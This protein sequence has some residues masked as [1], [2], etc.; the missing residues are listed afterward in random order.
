MKANN[1]KI[2]IWLEI[3][4]LGALFIKFAN[5]L[6]KKKAKIIESNFIDFAK[7]EEREVEKLIKGKENFNKFCCDSGSLIKDYFIPHNGNG[8]KPKILRTKSLLII[9][10]ITLLVKITVTGYLFFIYPNQA[11]MSEEITAKLLDLI[12][13]DRQNNNLYSLTVNPVL[14]KAALA[15]AQDMLANNY[16]AHYGPDGKKPWDW[17][18]RDAYPYLYAGENLAINFSSAGNVHAALMQSP[19][20]RKNILN[21]NYQNVGLAVLNGEINNQP[22]SILVEMFAGAKKVAPALTQ[23]QGVQ[24]KINQTPIIKPIPKEKTKPPETELGEILATTT[25]AAAEIQ[26]LSPNIELEK[27][28]N[29]KVSYINIVKDQR[30]SLAEKLISY[31]KYFYS[32]LLALM[33]IALLINIFV[34]IGIQHQPI[35]VQ[36]LLVILFVAG[37]LSIRLHI[38]ENIFDKIAII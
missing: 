9:I 7:K 36:T 14:T 25:V 15:K 38:L 21:S 20:H 1:K 10:L 6:F 24:P 32:V 5:F 26:P 12:N 16:F 13:L 28:L 17:V 2:K 33:I 37:L 11:K 35:I 3:L 19:S 8:H 30:I 31:S 34:H 4:A 23:T 29:L 18:D 27:N 22:T